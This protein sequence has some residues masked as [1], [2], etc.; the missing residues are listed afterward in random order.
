MITVV[1]IFSFSLIHHFG[2]SYDPPEGKKKKRYESETKRQQLKNYIAP[3][4]FLNS[5]FYS[6]TLHL[7]LLHT[8][9]FSLIPLSLFLS[10]SLSLSLS[11][12][13]ELTESEQKTDR[14]KGT[15]RFRRS[16]EQSEGVLQRKIPYHEGKK[17][18]QDQQIKNQVKQNEGEIRIG[19]QK[20]IQI[21]IK[22]KLIG[23]E[24]FAIYLI[25]SDCFQISRRFQMFLLAVL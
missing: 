13:S 25:Q 2:V 21:Q 4:I 18:N 17:T 24:R 19:T 9:L 16:R 7:S 23:S 12:L 14:T 15:A 10:L 1:S 3:S 5:S 8:T 11:D 22:K 6:R 20:Q